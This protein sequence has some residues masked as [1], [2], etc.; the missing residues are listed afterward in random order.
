MEE[1]YHLQVEK[2][3]ELESLSSK[4]G[5]DLYYGDETHVC[6]EGYVPY[7]WQFPGEDVCFLSEKSYKFNCLGLINRQN[8]CIWQVTRDNIDAGVVLDF[9]ERL[10]FGIQRKTFVVLDNARIHKSKIIRERIPYWQKRGLFLFFLP[11]YSPHLNIAETLWR[12]LKKE[13]LDPPDYLTEDDLAYA[14]NRCLAAMGKD[15]KINFSQFS[16]N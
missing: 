5:I 16:L 3:R 13:W 14:L 1:H 4:G 6:S 8:D 2:L 12:K 15:M 10:S 7:G 9:L 11:P